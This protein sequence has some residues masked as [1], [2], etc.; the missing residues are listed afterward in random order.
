MKK[1]CI[2]PLSFILAVFVWIFIQSDTGKASFL[3]DSQLWI[4]D[5]AINLRSKVDTSH[6][7]KIDFVTFDDQYQK[8]LYPDN[9][10][11]SQIPRDILANLLE[12]IPHDSV[13]AIFVNVDIAYKYDDHGESRLME[14]LENWVNSDTAPVLVLARSEK[15]DNWSSTRF[16]KF[17]DNKKVFWAS[18]GFHSYN[19]FLVREVTHWHCIEYEGQGIFVPSLSLIASVLTSGESFVLP[20]R[21]NVNDNIHRNIKKRSLVFYN[22]LNSSSK[23]FDKITTISACNYTH[24]K[25]CKRQIKNRAE[26]LFIGD[27]RERFS[28]N[29][30]PVGEMPA[31]LVHIN[32]ARSL[33]IRRKMDAS[34]F[35]KL[36]LLFFYSLW[37]WALFK[38]LQYI[39]TKSEALT[40]RLLGKFV[41]SLT[42]PLIGHWLVSTI[43]TITLVLVVANMPSFITWSGLVI[44]GF[45]L[46][47][48]LF[49]FDE[50]LA[51]RE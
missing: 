4:S 38:F 28:Y 18:N 32:A 33:A 50:F 36:L 21:C 48:C 29:A 19:D 9:R 10:P 26:I 49:F 25:H 47:F 3:G 8:L 30:T 24:P 6:L 45:F 23:N 40:S 42:M 11:Y 46:S 44:P 43:A 20:D 15:V 41:H 7:N 14:T 16:D 13:K 2:Y 35:A 34:I 37:V 51:E 5:H 31:T 39:R 27:S 17:V 12:S 1:W 22:I